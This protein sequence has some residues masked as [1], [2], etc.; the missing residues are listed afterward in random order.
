VNDNLP[1]NELPKMNKKVGAVLIAAVLVTGLVEFQSVSVMKAKEVEKQ[2]R[3]IEFSAPTVWTA[4]V[5]QCDTKDG[6][7]TRY[8]VPSSYNTGWQARLAPTKGTK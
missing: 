2:A 7:R 4:T 8:Y 5:T 1:F 6:C 3:Q